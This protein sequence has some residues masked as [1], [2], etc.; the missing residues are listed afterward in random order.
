MDSSP[1][2]SYSIK[3]FQKGQVVIPVNL[4]KKYNIEIGDQIE[5]LQKPEGILLKASSKKTH[6][7]QKTDILFGIF[8]DNFPKNKK[9][10]KKDIAK[11]TERAFVKGWKK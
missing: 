6:N 8:K 4:R 3:V 10:S 9:V 2:K 7:Q 11:A 1:K 5:A